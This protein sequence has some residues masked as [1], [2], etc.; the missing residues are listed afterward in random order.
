M[1]EN[2]KK[3]E[4]EKYTTQKQI[5]LTKQMDELV[6]SKALERHT[7]D[8]EIIRQAV[9]NYIN[10]SMSD[11]EIVHASLMENTRKIRYLENKV[12]LMAL[13]VFELVK[14]LM[15]SLPSRQVNSD[16]VVQHEF[17]AFMRNCTKILRNNHTGVLEAMILDSYEQQGS[18]G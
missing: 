12:E 16:T 5:R 1:K 6:K 8:S 17:E 11:T 14:L 9:A 2:R 15:K 4:H 18:E 3:E 10:R 13:V 7:T